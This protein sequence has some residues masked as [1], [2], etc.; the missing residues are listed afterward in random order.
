VTAGALSMS[1]IYGTLRTSNV[2]ANTSFS[3]LKR[4]WNIPEGNGKKEFKI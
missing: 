2:P 3:G 4:C 1:P